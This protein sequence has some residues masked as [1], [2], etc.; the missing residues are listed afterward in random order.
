MTSAAECRD[1]EMLIMRR[2]YLLNHER[3]ES[4]PQAPRDHGVRPAVA[5]AQEQAFQPRA[6]RKVGI[7]HV[8][9]SYQYQRVKVRRLGNSEQRTGYGLGL[10]TPP[11]LVERYGNSNHGWIGLRPSS[12]VFAGMLLSMV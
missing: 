4:I 11:H 1:R 2:A 12:S 10:H 5:W 7:H 8:S 6:R 3:Q 9:R